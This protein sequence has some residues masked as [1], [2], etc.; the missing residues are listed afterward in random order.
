MLSELKD[1]T[2]FIPVPQIKDKPLLSFGIRFGDISKKV[3]KRPLAFP[4]P[5]G[6]TYKVLQGY[7][8][9]FSHNDKIS[10][11]AIDFSLSIGD[12]ICA[13]DNGFVVG[14]IQTSKRSG[15]S[16]KYINEANYITLYHPETGLYTQ[17]VHLEYQG[18]F[19]QI[20]D[21]VKKGHPIG[22]I[23]LSGFT[24]GPHLHFNVLQP[25]AEDWVST[26][27]DFEKG[28]RAIDLK[29]GQRITN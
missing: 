1:S 6:K 2:F 16:E 8:G 7:M 23:G 22:R 4:F 10:R 18:S 25:K 3:E 28:Y 9:S 11:Y 24:T 29:K 20:G 15:K 27:I 17:Y 13:A 21:A 5:K 14:V 19:V 12:I 26:P